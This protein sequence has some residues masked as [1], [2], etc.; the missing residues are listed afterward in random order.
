MTT[1]KNPWTNYRCAVLSV[2]G[3]LATNGE[4]VR[5]RIADFE[6]EELIDVQLDLPVGIFREVLAAA[7]LMGISEDGADKQ[8]KIERDDPVKFG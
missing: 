1:H 3:K 7:R 6:G 2:N 8:V 5:L 4:I